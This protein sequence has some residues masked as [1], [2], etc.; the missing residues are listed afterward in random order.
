MAAVG[1]RMVGDILTIAAVR[2]VC[3]WRYWCR[4]KMEPLVDSHGMEPPPAVDRKVIVQ[5]K[6]ERLCRMVHK[7]VNLDITVQVSWGVVRPSGPTAL[8]HGECPEHSAKST[9]CREAVQKVFQYV[10]STQW[11][12]DDGWHGV[13]QPGRRVG[14]CMIESRWYDPGHWGAVRTG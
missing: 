6:S 8:K 7:S 14:H 3:G 4:S 10:V 12:A 5:L 1:R 13:R 9:R 11:R 2:S